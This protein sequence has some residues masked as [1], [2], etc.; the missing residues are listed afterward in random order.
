MQIGIVGLGRMGSNMAKRLARGGARVVAWD[1]DNI[2]QR[3][4]ALSYFTVFSL[5]PLLILLTV[6]SSLGFGREAASGRL[7]GQIRGLIGID[8]AVFIQSLIKNAYRSDASV[9][10]TI[11]S[12]AMLLFGASAVFV[13]LRDSLNAIWRVRPRATGRHR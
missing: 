10:A 2:A 13:E 8:G 4:A 6:V 11:F 12:A 5:T 1:R 3:G 9:T 7:V